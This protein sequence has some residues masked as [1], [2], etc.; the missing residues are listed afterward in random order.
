MREVLQ[1]VFLTRNIVTD[2]F[3]IYML[4]LQLG[5]PTSVFTKKKNIFLLKSL[6]TRMKSFAGVY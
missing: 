3:N 4:I 2:A 1:T 6:F 5:K